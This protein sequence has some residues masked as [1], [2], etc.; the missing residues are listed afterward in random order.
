MVLNENSIGNF[1][2]QNDI[3]DNQ[4][5]RRKTK[6]LIVDDEPFNIMACKYIL[7]ATGLENIEK[8]CDT[9]LNGKIAVDMVKEHKDECYYDLILM[10]QN[11]P[12]LNGCMASKQ[13]R[14]YLYS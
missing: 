10:D 6:I 13:I 9:A 11:M 7:K 3:I 2:W 5:P 1:I 12:V 8:I 14:E 4:T